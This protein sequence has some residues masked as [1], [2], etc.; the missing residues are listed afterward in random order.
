MCTLPYFCTPTE[1]DFVST[2]TSVYGSAPVRVEC[3]E[4]VERIIPRTFKARGHAA[5]MQEAYRRYI[6]RKLT[7]G[8]KRSQVRAGTVGHK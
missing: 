2:Q 4:T 8:C 5:F 7:W 6:V 3:I 1:T